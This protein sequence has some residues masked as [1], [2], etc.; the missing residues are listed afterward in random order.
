VTSLV[1]AWQLLKKCPGNTLVTEEF[2][3]PVNQQME[4]IYNYCTRVLETLLQWTSAHRSCIHCFHTSI[5]HLF[6]SMYNAHIDNF[7]MTHFPAFIVYF[8]WSLQKRWLGVSLYM[9]LI[10]SNIYIFKSLPSNSR[11][12]YCNC[13][14]LECRHLCHCPLVTIHIPLWQA[15]GGLLP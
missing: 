5:V 14:G 13:L 9:Q 4:G 10:L 15:T 2:T 3:T 7:P 1:V 8:L 6:W 12:I 11:F